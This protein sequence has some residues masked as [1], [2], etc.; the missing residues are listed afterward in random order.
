MYHVTVNSFIIILRGLNYK[1]V[2]K[3]G[4]EKKVEKLTEKLTELIFHSEGYREI[5]STL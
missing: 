2:S 4:T 5:L 3:S 1:D